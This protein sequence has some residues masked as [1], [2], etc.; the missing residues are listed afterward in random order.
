MWLGV[1]V[2]ALFPAAHGRFYEAVD[3]FIQHPCRPQSAGCEVGRLSPR[4]LGSFRA[5]RALGLGSPLM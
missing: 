4:S 3:P 2:E 1:N 5:A